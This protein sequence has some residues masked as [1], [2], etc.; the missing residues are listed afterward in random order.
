VLPAETASR[1]SDYRDL[2]VESEISHEGRRYPR[3]RFALQPAAAS[4]W[5]IA[6]S[7]PADGRPSDL[8]LHFYIL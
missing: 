1:A 8:L 2:A 4:R 7:R 6:C 3:F 5:R